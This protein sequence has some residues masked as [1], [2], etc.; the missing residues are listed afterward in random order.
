MKIG[1]NPVLKVLKLNTMLQVHGNLNRY[2]L[3]LFNTPYEA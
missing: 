1:K 3:H 2:M